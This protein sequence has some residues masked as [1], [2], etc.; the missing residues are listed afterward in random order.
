MITPEQVFGLIASGEAQRHVGST[1]LNA[2]SSRS[3]TIFRLVIESKSGSS[4]VRVST[5]SLVDLAGSESVKQ[6][7]TTGV[8]KKEGHYINKSLL[9]LGHVIWKLSENR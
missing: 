1:L 3:H 4:S 8:R 7:K 9:T 6:A 5:L 2:F